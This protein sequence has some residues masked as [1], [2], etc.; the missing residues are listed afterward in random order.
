[1]MAYLI[2]SGLGPN[3]RHSDTTASGTGWTRDEMEHPDAPRAYAKSF[4]AAR[5][6]RG[7]GTT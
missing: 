3:Q 4:A 1:M 7:S 5:I 2:P 6:F